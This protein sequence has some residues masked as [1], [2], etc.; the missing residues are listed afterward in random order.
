MDIRD[1]KFNFQRDSVI[2]VASTEETSTHERR[3]NFRVGLP[4]VDS[5][6]ARYRSSHAGNRYLGVRRA[7]KKETHVS[8][9]CA[10]LAKYDVNR[11]QECRITAREISREAN[12]TPPPRACSRRLKSFQFPLENSPTPPRA[13]PRGLSRKNHGSGE[14]KQNDAGRGKKLVYTM[15]EGH[16]GGGSLDEREREKE[17]MRRLIGGW[18]GRAGIWKS[19]EVA[20]VLI[21]V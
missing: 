15:E 10:G 1:A 3:H 19:G 11:Q 5:G 13:D 4:S 17:R 8:K 6:N 20:V 12:T 9:R 2:S 14:E 21:A 18:L 7:E 16:R